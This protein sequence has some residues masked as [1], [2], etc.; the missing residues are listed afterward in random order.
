MAR[1]FYCFDNIT[2]IN[3]D[4]D[5]NAAMKEVEFCYMEDTHGDIYLQNIMQ[6]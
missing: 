3:T 1:G 4:D 5:E 2:V 6:D